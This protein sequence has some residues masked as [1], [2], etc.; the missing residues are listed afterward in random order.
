MLQRSPEAS[1]AS[2]NRRAFWLL[3]LRQWHW[4]SAAVSLLGTLL[5]GLLI[6]D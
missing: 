5:F 4:I 6:D 1:P 3:Q 2:S